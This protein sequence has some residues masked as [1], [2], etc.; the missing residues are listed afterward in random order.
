MITFFITLNIILFYGWKL[1]FGEDLWL[2]ALGVNV[3]QTAGLLFF[4]TYI[5]R[6]Y[7]RTTNKQKE[8]WLL[9]T[10]GGIV[11]LTANIVW[12]FFLVGNNMLYSDI[13]SSLWLL[14]Y[15]FFLSGLVYWIRWANPSTFKKVYLFNIIIFMITVTSIVVHYLIEPILTLSN[16]SLWNTMITVAYPIIDISLMFVLVIMYYLIL[17]NKEKSVMLL[18]V[19]GFSLH[20][21]ADSYSVYLDI[22]G[23]YT[24]GTLADLL[25]I[26]SVW[27]IGTAGF[28][29]KEDREEP[30]WEIEKTFKKFG[31]ILPYAS[32][33]VLLILVTLSYQWD[34]NVLS[35][36]LFIIIFMIIARQLYI[37]KEN[38]KLIDEFKHLAYH[39][40]LTG[41]KNRI[42][43]EEHLDYEMQKCRDN[44]AALLLIDLD[45]FKVINDTLGHQAGDFIL[46]KISKYLQQILAAD[47]QVFR[48]GGDEF[49]IILPDATKEKCI[50]VTETVLDK[51]QKPF[52]IHGH[53]I[54]VT[55]S[56][57][58]SLFPLHARTYEELFKYADAAMYLAKDG[59]K[60]GYRFYDDDLNQ[61]MARRMR[62]ESDLRKA[63]E[64]KQF[65]VYYQPKLELKTKKIVGMEA[66]LRWKHPE[67]GWI[68]PAEFIPI[69]EETGQIVSIGEWVLNEACKQNVSWQQRGLPLVSVSVNVS[70]RQFQQG[71]FLSVVEKAL[72]ESG[73]QSQFLEIE[74]TE[75]IM[76]N[77][78]DSIKILT[79]LRKK[80][81]KIAIDDF[82]KGYS[83]L[84]MIRQLPIDTIKLDKS[85]ID[86]IDDEMQLAM[87]KTIILLGIDLNLT[88]VA[89]GIEREYQLNKLIEGHCHIGQ[90]YLFSKAVKA[91]KM[92]K[93][94]KD[95][96]GVYLQK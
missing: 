43:F 1:L 63:L 62:I 83:S 70:V 47:T 50:K 19:T 92:E 71:K 48:L 37:V 11:Y 22:A 44:S 68:S 49:A 5:H 66:L 84:H 39:D 51:F 67:L 87:V 7:R 17:K 60:N 55:A 61:I 91:E 21:I 76:Q 85:F 59:G 36:G 32:T 45:R 90:G 78:N 46:M 42:N 69:A 73:L 26:I 18:V 53:E 74:V 30:V 24:Q 64:E 20:V 38:D 93:I 54:I 12:F 35:I 58:I 89:E 95:N 3:L 52:S 82:G 40:P 33:I 23:S 94:L 41:L 29:V 56:I 16:Y 57:G 13:A 96:S 86:D 72:R 34:L 25:W 80:G 10:V 81:V 27:L 2:G 8:F 65:K 79:S 28:Y 15:V 9:L 75:S 14:A 6:A 88:V 4:V 77:I 31:N